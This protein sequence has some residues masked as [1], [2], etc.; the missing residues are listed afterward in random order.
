VCMLSDILEAVDER[1]VAI[2]A[3]FDAVEHTILLR[4]LQR[5]YGVDGAVL[6][7]FESYLSGRRQSV[8]RDSKASSFTPIF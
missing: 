7:W 3:A 5:F 2:L 4:Y 8:R 6:H 1:N